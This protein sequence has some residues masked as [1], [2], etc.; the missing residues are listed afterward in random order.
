MLRL[1]F[2][3][4]LSVIPLNNAAGTDLW[5]SE[6]KTAEAHENLQALPVVLKQKAVVADEYIRLGDLFSG[7]AS[8]AD[9]KIVA[10]APALG[11]EAVLTAEWLKNWRRRTKSVGRRQTAK[12][13]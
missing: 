10:P 5:A 7:L 13:R 1:I 2:I 6:E 11:K 12:Q 3:V 9:K 8:D 4:V